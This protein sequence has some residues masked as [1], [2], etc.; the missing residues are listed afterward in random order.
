MRKG[1]GEK[2]EGKSSR[3]TR[4]PV[5]SPLCR[6]ITVMWPS[7]HSSSCQLGQTTSMWRR[8][9]AKQLGNNSGEVSSYV[10]QSQAPRWNIWLK[11]YLFLSRHLDNF[12]CSCAFK[13]VLFLF[14][15][16]AGILLR[17]WRNASERNYMSHFWCKLTVFIL[18]HETCMM[19]LSHTVM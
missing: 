9:R 1:V 4:V 17:L 2:E 11:V 13:H 18:Y 5:W 10:R 15:L 19:C 7:L 12:V 16:L 14:L 3:L 8:W 6:S